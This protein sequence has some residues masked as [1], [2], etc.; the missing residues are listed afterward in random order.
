YRASLGDQIDYKRLLRPRL[1]LTF[2]SE[3]NCSTVQRPPCRIERCRSTLLCAD[4]FLQPPLYSF[5]ND[6]PLEYGDLVA[7]ALLAVT[8]IKFIREAASPKSPQG[9]IALPPGLNH[10]SSLMARQL[11]DVRGDP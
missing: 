9:R 7:F 5:V 10:L 8:A 3:F 6:N 2:S 1:C 4:F 11:C